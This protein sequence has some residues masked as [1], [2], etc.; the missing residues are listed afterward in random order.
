[1]DYDLGK[2]KLSLT[3]RTFMMRE[4]TG[5]LANIADG[6]N[7]IS[8]TNKEDRKEV[9]DYYPVQGGSGSSFQ[10]HKVVLEFFYSKKPG[11]ISLVQANQVGG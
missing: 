3:A 4:P 10:W 11:G 1:M 6:L 5:K 7:G 9:P 8:L 2:V